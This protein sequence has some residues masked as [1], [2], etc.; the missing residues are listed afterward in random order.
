MISADL[1]KQKQN[2]TN[3]FEVYVYW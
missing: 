2:L 1:R 3:Q